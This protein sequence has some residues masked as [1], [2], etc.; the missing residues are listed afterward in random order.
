[1]WLDLDA[2]DA[3]LLQRSSISLD[4]RVR[5]VQVM[6]IRTVPSSQQI[7]WHPRT[8]ISKYII[9]TFRDFLSTDVLGFVLHMVTVIVNQTLD[10]RSRD[11]EHYYRS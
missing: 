5:V 3:L 1:M 2:L 7:R 9:G 6:C 11:L 10:G 4:I 8:L